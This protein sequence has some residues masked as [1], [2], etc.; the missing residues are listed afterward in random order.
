MLV[1][2]DMTI[3]DEIDAL[4]LASDLRRRQ[5]VPLGVLV[6]DAV[7]GAAKAKEG[8]IQRAIIRRLALLGIVAVH[9]PNGG[10]RGR[11]EGARLKAEGVMAGFP[12]L[13]LIGTA[14]RVGFLEVKG[15]TGRLSDAQRDRIAML[16]ARGH[17]V[18]V[19]R[20][21]DYAEQVVRQWGWVV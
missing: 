6:Q 7:K 12:D 21:Q 14:G 17:L 20:C 10:S 4:G 13:I 2:Q 9:V 8:L 1:R 3:A 11:I 15:P 5:P 16:H 19:V 18:A